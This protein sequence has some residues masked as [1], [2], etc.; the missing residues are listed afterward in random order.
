MAQLT[1]F[2][3]AYSGRFGNTGRWY[4]CLS[5]GGSLIGTGD[6]EAKAWAQAERWLARER[7]GRNQPTQTGD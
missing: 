5:K 6:S 7:D 1:Q 3:E 4:V 2:P